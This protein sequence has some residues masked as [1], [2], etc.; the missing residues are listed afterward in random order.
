MTDI[1]VAEEVVDEART[2]L[3]EALVAD[4]GDSL[5]EH[6]LVPGV[7]LWIRVNVE[8]FGET[9]GYLRESQRFR[10][11]DFLSAIDWLPSAAALTPTSTPPSATEKRRKPKR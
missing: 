4:L 7:D 3:L 9:A 1:E 10:Y 11:F 5:V 2:A 8:S 6:H